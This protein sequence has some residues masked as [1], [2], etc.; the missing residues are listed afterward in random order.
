VVLSRYNRIAGR[1]WIAIPL[2]PYLYSVNN[3][4]DVPLFADAKL[5]PLLR[6]DYLRNIASVLDDDADGLRER[7][8]WNQLVGS[9]Y[10]RTLYGFRIATRPEQDDE[11]IRI[12]NSSPNRE[13]YKLLNRNCADFVK[14]IINFYYPKAIHRSII[15]NLGVMTPKQAAKSL[16]HSVRHHPEMQLTTF[17][18]PQVP[19]LKRS[20]PVHG[21]LESLVLA[22]KYVTPVLLFHPIFDPATGLEMPL[23]DA[24]RRAYE[25]SV[26]ALKRD[27]E[28][29][30]ST[31]D[32]RKLAASAEP[33]LD[34]AG[35]PFLRIQ[36][37]G[38]TVHVGLCR[39]NA[40]RLTAPPELVQELLL[41]RLE[42]ELKPGK[43]SR[44]SQQ[45]VKNDWKM[46]Q[47][48][49]EAR[50]AALAGER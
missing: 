42:H 5:V 6:H 21:V 23:T 44:A 8:S 24:Q 35:Q 15:A 34:A 43:P 3:P 9:A 38:R 1:D 37:D 7:D 19:G 28:E 45:Q 11:L 18:I 29:A 41:T 33:Q 40:L 46:L 48:A 50:Q 17:I 20:K 32:W 2:I 39:G 30:E 25:S 14:Q 22:K 26:S 12:L 4:E 16:V 27:A 36:M 49:V 13:T 47:G 31:P 10:N